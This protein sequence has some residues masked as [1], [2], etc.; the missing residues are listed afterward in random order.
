MNTCN[1]IFQYMPIAGQCQVKSSSFRI[2][3]YREGI[4]S[5]C[6]WL[7]TTRCGCSPGLSPVTASEPPERAACAAPW[8]CHAA[9]SAGLW[10]F[11]RWRL[12]WQRRS[13]G[14]S[15]THNN[16]LHPRWHTAESRWLP[17]ATG[18]LKRESES[19]SSVLQHWCMFAI[20]CLYTATGH[21][22]RKISEEDSAP[23][24]SPRP[25]LDKELLCWLVLIPS[26]W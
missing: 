12:P 8:T 5:L 15:V 9:A 7:K 19:G 2:Q 6:V 13:G 21:F 10:R 3:K 20:C 17:S 22:K 4:E 18:K 16:R 24:A 25:L 1:A 26:L 23:V 14:C 11:A